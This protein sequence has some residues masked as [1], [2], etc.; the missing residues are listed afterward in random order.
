MNLPTY[1]SDPQVQNLQQIIE[2]IQRG[3]LLIP[4]FQRLF[5]WT[6]DQ[7]LTLLQSIREGLPIGSI[8]VWRTTE[9][10][11]DT[12]PEIAGKSANRI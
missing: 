10:K 11:L 1:F 8:L 2:D 9:H 7:R 12:F 3:G 6:D 5:Q 4:R